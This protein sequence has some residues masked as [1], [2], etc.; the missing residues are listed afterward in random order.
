MTSGLG[1]KVC[2]LL[3]AGLCCATAAF[4]GSGGV[5]YSP[6]KG[7][8]KHGLSVTVDSRG[9]ESDGYRPFKVKITPWPPVPATSERSIRVTVAP[10]HYDNGSLDL[11]VS[12]VFELKIGAAAVEG[13]ILVPQD[14]I[15]GFVLVD[16][17]ED[18]ERLR[19]MDIRLNSS[20]GGWWNYNQNAT[21]ILF[22]DSDVWSRDKQAAAVQARTSGRWKDPD[23]FLL[24]DVR[25]LSAMYPDPHSGQAQSM[26][27]DSGELP[28]QPD[29]ATVALVHDHSRFDMLAPSEAPEDWLALTGYDVIYISRQDLVQMAEEHPRRWAALLDWLETGPLLI[30]ADGG[31]DF[32]HLPQLEALLKVTPG[33]R[34]AAS[35][36]DEDAG[37]SG[38]VYPGEK[39]FEQAMNALNVPG[40][41]GW[42]YRNGRPVYGG[43]GNAPGMSIDEEAL[44]L[45]KEQRTK[46][47]K[48]APFVYRTVGLGSIAVLREE[49]PL[50]GSSLMWGGLFATAGKHRQ[51]WQERHGVSTT[52][53]NPG[54][55]SFLIPGVGMSP[56]MAFLALITL[57]MFV[58]G[59][60]N[61]WFLRRV[62]RAHLLLL[63]VPAGALVMTV[64]L[65]L[66]A[67]ITDG[68]G[69]SSRIRSFTRLD[70]RGR[71]VSWSRHSYYASLAPTKGL[72]FPDDAAVY[73]I[74]PNAWKTQNSS[75]QRRLRWD[76]G[77]Q[78][79]Q[80]G[81]V[82]PRTVTQFLVVRAT[83]APGG[84]KFS[85]PGDQAE[86][87]EI[88]NNLDVPIETLLA[89]NDQGAVFFARD[90]APG[91][92]A[93]LQVT[94][95]K[96][97]KTEWKKMFDL[98]EPK[99]PTQDALAGDQ[100]LFSFMLPDFRYGQWMD[101]QGIES[102]LLEQQLREAQ[103]GRPAP[104]TWIAQTG[105]TKAVPIAVDYAAEKAGFH[106]VGGNW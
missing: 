40:Q 101:S 42:V 14:R 6:V 37:R 96:D 83:E 66:Y 105:R 34:E 24:P 41:P 87:P 26:M 99:S 30:V 49:N 106:L 17:Y 19:D 29:I 91:A 97:S 52:G 54:Y 1:R 4:A 88:T 33:K 60:V 35:A 72:V 65:F 93:K 70:D 43:P 48:S 84:V 61:Y 23:T 25:T 73:S 82:L 81:Y 103:F 64:G 46:L 104:R 75:R 90:I 62:G 32:A 2:A 3:I 18:G 98:N 63:T 80:T 74:V 69:V 86:P 47:V 45:T 78:Q 56:V 50:P 31:E 16:V 20:R 9:I 8:N 12:Q 21:S 57:F 13:T 22:L 79:F 38:W 10:N 94:N 53:R 95:L 39:D 11:E 7:R 92:K 58:V 100:N 76:G 68:L 28:K 102:S 15:F 85:A 27:Y 36:N 51:R 5:G 59:P 77:E 44:K 89:R 67:L 71:A 55:W